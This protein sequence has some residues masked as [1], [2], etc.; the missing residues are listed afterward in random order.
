[1]K[2]YHSILGLGPTKNADILI[3]GQEK[4]MALQTD[5]ECKHAF[6][7]HTLLPVE[8]FFNTF[9]WGTEYLGL[10]D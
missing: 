10:E 8:V 3:D 9:N 1:M 2:F 6:T 5:N 4:A 7:R